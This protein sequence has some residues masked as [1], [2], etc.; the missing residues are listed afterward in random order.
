MQAKAVLVYGGGVDYDFSKHF[1]GRAEYRGFVYDRL[2][3]NLA[4]LRSGATTH[5]ARPSAGI[6][7]RF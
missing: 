5:T 3:F 4:A 7:F 1:V 6:V 2:D